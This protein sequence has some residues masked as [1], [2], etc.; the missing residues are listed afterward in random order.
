ML[1]GVRTRRQ[2]FTLPNTAQTVSLSFLVRWESPSPAS[3]PFSPLIRRYFA[4]D[5]SSNIGVSPIKSWQG[6]T[7]RHV[8]KFRSRPVRTSR[9][10]RQS[11]LH[12]EA[13]TRFPRI[14]P[15]TCEGNGPGPARFP[16]PQ[17]DLRRGEVHYGCGSVPQHASSS[18]TS[19]WRS[20]S[21][22]HF[23]LFAVASP[24]SS[25]ARRSL[26]ATLLHN[27]PFSQQFPPT[28]LSQH[29]FP[30]GKQSHLPRKS[31]RWR[32]RSYV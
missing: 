4:A 23:G 13:R 25:G 19:I 1:F 32:V 26:L 17:P 3:H 6:L 27:S 8:N 11:N 2:R 18:T 31:S 14:G 24:I 29:E 5:S 30:R 12:S 10:T 22:L 28:A 7:L 9:P 15:E 21:Q 20:T 16:G